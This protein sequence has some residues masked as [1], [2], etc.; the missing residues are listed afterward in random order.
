MRLPFSFVSKTD[1]V[2]WPDILIATLSGIPARTIF[3]TAVRRKS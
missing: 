1:R 3:L 2:L